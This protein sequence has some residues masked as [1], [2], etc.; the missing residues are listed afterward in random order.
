MHKY[1]NCPIGWKIQREYIVK[2]LEE[3]L[4]KKIYHWTS[5]IISFTNILMLHRHIIKTLRTYFIM[6]SNLLDNEYNHFELIRWNEM[7]NII[8]SWRIIKVL[9]IDQINKFT[10]MMAN[11][12]VLQTTKL[13][14]YLEWS[15]NYEGKMFICWR[16]RNKYWA[17]ILITQIVKVHKFNRRWNQTT[18]KHEYIELWKKWR[19]VSPL[20]GYESL[21]GK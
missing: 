6:F 10:Y 19:Y 21:Y 2:Y 15:W 14:E 5:K 4:N 1:I 3:K 17:K 8:Q 13:K 18:T 9:F 12:H 16:L 20:H 11:L 7:K